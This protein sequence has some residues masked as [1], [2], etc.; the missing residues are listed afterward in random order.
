M[1]K[2]QAC[3]IRL[4][5]RTPLCSGMNKAQ[6]CAWFVQSRSFREEFIDFLRKYGIDYD[7]RY[8]WD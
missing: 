8:L 7:E 3:A 6:A 1:N 2:A 4:S 5:R